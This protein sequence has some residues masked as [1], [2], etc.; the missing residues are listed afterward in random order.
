MKAINSQSINL[1]LVEHGRSSNYGNVSGFYG[2][3]SVFD[4]QCSERTTML[5]IFNFFFQPFN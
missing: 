3:I 1:L 4:L 2:D 5:Q